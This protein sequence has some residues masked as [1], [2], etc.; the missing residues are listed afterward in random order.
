MLCSC[1]S[2]ARAS[3]FSPLKSSCGRV[4]HLPEHN[5]RERHLLLSLRTP[6]QPPLQRP[7]TS[8]QDPQVVP[9]CNSAT[10]LW[11]TPEDCCGGLPGGLG[12]RPEKRA[13]QAGSRCVA[14]A[15]VQAAR[16]F[17]REA[18]MSPSRIHVAPMGMEGTCAK[19]AR[20]LGPKL[21]GDCHVCMQSFSNLVWVRRHLQPAQLLVATEAGQ[22]GGA[23]GVNH[24]ARCLR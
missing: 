20:P 22:V 1:P 5:C 23:T 2:S 17:E 16:T 9:C 19:P 14:L 12:G 13:A 3:S 15:R 24:A 10:P 6:P 11:R 4:T 8:P 18:G 21:T 7:H